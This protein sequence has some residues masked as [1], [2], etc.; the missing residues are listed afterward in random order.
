MVELRWGVQYYL[1]KEQL[2]R[3]IDRTAVP[4]GPISEGRG[5]TQHL[6]EGNVH[7][8]CDLG[9]QSSCLHFRPFLFPMPPE[10]QVHISHSEWG[11]TKY[12]FPCLGHRWRNETLEA[13]INPISVSLVPEQ[14]TCTFDVL[15]M[16]MGNVSNMWPPWL[17]L[18]LARNVCPTRARG[19]GKSPSLNFW[20]P[21]SIVDLIPK[22]DDFCTAV[23]LRFDFDFSFR[24]PAICLR[25]AQ[26]YLYS[27][28]GIYCRNLQIL[29]ELLRLQLGFW[30]LFLGP[31]S[32]YLCYLYLHNCFSSVCQ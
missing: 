8:A 24:P 18:M 15:R 28:C 30:H 26:M 21:D 12:F 7:Q 10:R 20:E 11:H 9:W 17:F 13:G 14:S 29:I 23:P 27:I 4:N 25:G 16:P 3:S 2:D 5:V 1:E 19:G 22:R 31:T 6:D 32:G